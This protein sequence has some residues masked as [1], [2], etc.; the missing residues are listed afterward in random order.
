M[1]YATRPL[2]GHDDLRLDPYAGAQA[3]RFE[4]RGA[5]VEVALSPRG[6][7]M[8]RRLSCG[9]DV[10]VSLPAQ[11]FAG[12]AAQ[13]FEN[14]DGTCTVTLVLHHADPALCVPLLATDDPEA[15]A[16]DWRSWARNLRLPMLLAS[17]DGMQVVEDGTDA[18]L[19]G[20][21]LITAIPLPRRRR[22]TTAKHRPN[23][24]RRRQMGRSGRAVRIE[25]REII[26]RG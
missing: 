22:R 23:F 12:V 14:A 1:A 16:A 17:V 25:A 20:G 10:N 24:M 8:R 15:A 18:P 9:I 6:A 4:D 3:L 2:W 11:G 21:A 26:A 5:P 19:D 13:A 7:V